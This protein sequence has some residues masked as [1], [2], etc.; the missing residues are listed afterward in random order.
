K[1]SHTE[2]LSSS[3]IE[4]NSSMKESK[5]DSRSLSLLKKE[6]SS[7]NFL[8]EPQKLR[9]ASTSELY[10]DNVSSVHNVLMEYSTIKTQETLPTLTLPEGS[11]LLSSSE[12]TNKSIKVDLRPGHSS[13]MPLLSPPGLTK[14][15][16]SGSESGISHTLQAADNKEM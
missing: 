3:S 6:T 11:L 8:S 5:D 16:R 15:L 7:G 4:G 14:R 1:I 9:C 13:K 2:R 12:I 10:S